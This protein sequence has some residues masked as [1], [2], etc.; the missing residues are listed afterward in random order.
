MPKAVYLHG[1]Q[2]VV[3][4]TPSAAVVAGDVV[5]QGELV[6]VALHPIDANTL[7]GLAVTGV[8]VVEKD[9]TSIGAGALVY[10]DNTN[11]KATATA[12]GNKLM[13][14]AVKAALAADTKVTVLLTP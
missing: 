11:K 14:K 5:V 6:G 13:G 1:E 12:T 3:D 2:T 8:F 7:G 9:N 10:W 4:Y